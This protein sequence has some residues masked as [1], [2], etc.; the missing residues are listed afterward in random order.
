M[1]HS[2]PFHVKNGQPAETAETRREGWNSHQRMRKPDLGPVDGTIAYRLHHGQNIVIPRVKRNLLQRSLFPPQSG[3]PKKELQP[4]AN[5]ITKK[6]EYSLLL[7]L[8]L[9]C[10]KRPI[11]RVVSWA[12]LH[13]F[14]GY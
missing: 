5:L 8:F 3:Q 1:R 11:M 13:S 7:F 10:A 4:S 12:Y 6:S 9:Q 2:N 14:H